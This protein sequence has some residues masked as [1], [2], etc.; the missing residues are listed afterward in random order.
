GIERRPLVRA[1]LDGAP[2][3]PVP[4][5]GSSPSIC[6]VF[7]PVLMLS[8]AAKFPFTPLAMAVV[9]A[10][11]MSYFLTRTVVPTLVHYLLPAEMALYQEGEDSAAAKAAGVIWRIHEAFDRQF[12]KLRHAS[13]GLLEWVLHTRIAV[14]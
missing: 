7:V 13:H 3:I 5:C 8:A 10:M 1:L 14:V 4:A 9:F 2:Q 6:I 11:L 12:E